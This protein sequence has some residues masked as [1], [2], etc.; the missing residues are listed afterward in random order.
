MIDSFRGTVTVRPFFV[1]IV[2]FGVNIQVF[3]VLL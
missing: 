3:L 2:T 1:V